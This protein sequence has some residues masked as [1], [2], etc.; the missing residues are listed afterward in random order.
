MRVHWTDK[1]RRLS[2]P[3]VCGISWNRESLD[4]LVLQPELGLYPD[5]GG[6]LLKNFKKRTS[7]IG[8]A[9]LVGVGGDILGTKQRLDQR[10]GVEVGQEATAAVHAR[11]D[12]ARW[13][14]L[15]VE[16]G[17]PRTELLGLRCWV[18]VAGAT[19]G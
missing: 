3:H 5:S 17:E 9:F 1:A 11:D 16:M 10:L 18:A 13:R 6:K 14:L 8:F 15:A 12:G 7:I 2:K 4:C 19:V